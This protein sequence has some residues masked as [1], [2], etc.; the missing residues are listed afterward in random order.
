MSTCQPRVASDLRWTGRRTETQPPR[1][2]AAL[3]QRLTL[4]N[5]RAQAGARGYLARV[6]HVACVRNQHRHLHSAP[7]NVRVAAM[8]AIGAKCQRCWQNCQ[9]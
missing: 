4:H 5:S 3:R 8:H 2:P 7:I 6:L 9:Q 1:A